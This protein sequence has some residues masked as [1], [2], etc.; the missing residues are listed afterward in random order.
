MKRI[1]W[2]DTLKGIGIIL[3]VLGHYPAFSYTGRALI[4]IYSF[5]MP[6]FLFIGGYL[7]SDIKNRKELT[8]KLKNNV[9][10]L[11]L[12]YFGFSIISLVFSWPANEQVASTYLY[13]IFYGLGTE[14]LPNVPLWFFT[15]YFTGRCIFAIIV[16]LANAV[17]KNR[18]AVKESVLFIL[19]FTLVAAAY[20]YR[21][22]LYK[23]RLPWNPEMS[24]L[25][26][27]FYYLGYQFR[28]FKLK[29]ELPV[30]WKAALCSLAFAL[31]VPAAL[32][33]TRVDINASYFGRGMWYFYFAASLGL[34][35]CVGLA[36]LLS[37]V[38]LVKILLN[39]LGENSLYVVGFHIPMNF[40]AGAVILPFMPVAVQAAY[41]TKSVIGV[42]FTVITTIL[43]SLLA[44]YLWREA[45][46]S[47]VSG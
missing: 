37:R 39:Y 31:W 40:V 46:K 29:R 34:I 20:V 27:G 45:K 6:L 47:L 33:G 41:M 44:G 15:F 36:H 24:A 12:P 3:M 35:W 11:A 7:F 42:L 8:N 32:Y 16:Y 25:C 21:L 9:G 30:I 38:K 19:T 23:T 17:G 2:V 26:M 22:K 1:E 14:N 28:H 13:G 5:H 18:R 43:L 10:S 4:L